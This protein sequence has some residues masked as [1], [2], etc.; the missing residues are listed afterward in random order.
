MLGGDDDG[1]HAHRHGLATL[2]S[3]LASHLRLAVRAN[4]GAGAVL[5]HLCIGMSME[6]DEVGVWCMECGV[7]CMILEI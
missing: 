5:A 3:V 2:Q 1:V 4:P 6:K 7:W